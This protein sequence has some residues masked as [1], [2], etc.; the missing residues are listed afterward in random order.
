MIETAAGD[1]RSDGF[2]RLQAPR[3]AALRE[4]RFH[5]KS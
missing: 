1:M 4:S 5:H 2:A 3:S